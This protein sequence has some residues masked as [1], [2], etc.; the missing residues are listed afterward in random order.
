MHILK[1]LII[2]YTIFQTENQ[3]KNEYMPNYF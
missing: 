1:Y 2:Q 3:Q